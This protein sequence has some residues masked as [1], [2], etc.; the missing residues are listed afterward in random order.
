MGK[1]LK[2]KEIGKGI[3]QRPSGTYEARAQIKGIQINESNND[4]EKLKT[5]FQKLKENARNG[6]YTQNRDITL[7]DWYEEWF[8]TFKA[9]SLT[10][11]SIHPM[12]N[13]YKTVFSQGSGLKKVSDILSIDLQV[14]I[15]NARASGKS[16]KAIRDV[17]GQLNKCFESAKNN[18]IRDSNPCCDLVVCGKKD[19]RIPT[20]PRF[21]SPEEQRIFLHEVND[22]WY[23][24]MFYIMLLTGLR[25]GEI[26]GLK[27]KD[28]DIHGKHI[29]I[30]QSLT[31]QY[32]YGLKTMKLSVLKTPNSYR[33]I[34]FMGEAEKMF[35]AQKIKQ[36]LLKKELGKRWR[37]KDDFSDLVFCSTLG[38]PVTRYIAQREINKIVEQ[39]NFKER[40]EAVQQNREMNVFEKLSP[41]AMRHTFC[42]NCFRCGMN[43]KAVQDLMGHRYYSTTIDIYTHMM[44]KD[45]SE[46]AL[47]YQELLP[48]TE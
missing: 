35:K 13:R 2:G 39:I 11:S 4:L 12:K 22:N 47:K 43:P 15:N 36:D 32:Y 34:P 19:N 42:S 9:K 40:I 37:G 20:Q 3:R 41:H 31:C 6:I 30:R 10:E 46:E 29:N 26:G 25:I 21:L 24:E 18:H 45:Y 1:D 14:D 8:N 44:G 33:R 16:V 48:H 7:N 23:K 38:S 5:S 27:W 17:V 28:V